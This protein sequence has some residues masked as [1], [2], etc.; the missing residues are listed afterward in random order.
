MDSREEKKKNLYLSIGLI[1][2][3]FC[4]TGAT[5]AYFALTAS[6]NAITGTVGGSDS[7][8]NRQ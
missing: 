8:F 5:Y 7:N 6:N 4:V 3:A 1:L 2:F